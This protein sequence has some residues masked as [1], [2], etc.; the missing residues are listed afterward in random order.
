MFQFGNNVQL[1]TWHTTDTVHITDGYAIV[2]DSWND[3]NDLGTGCSYI[4]VQT[5]NETTGQESWI[6]NQTIYANTY[7]W[8]SSTSTWTSSS[9]LFETTTTGSPTPAL[10]TTDTPDG[11]PDTTMTSNNNED[12]IFIKLIGFCVKY[13][14]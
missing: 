7:T 12:D 9:V 8:E 14:W 6:Y 2:G 5:F 10:Y 13:M 11:T 1:F 3:D 4:Y